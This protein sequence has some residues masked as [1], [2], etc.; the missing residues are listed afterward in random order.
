MDNKSCLTYPPYFMVRLWMALGLAPYFIGKT[1]SLAGLRHSLEKIGFSVE[2]ST[3]IFHYPYPDGL[4]RWLEHSLHKL[5][6]GKLDNAIRQGL[7]LLDKLEGKRTRYLTGRYIAVKAI[8]KG[9][10]EQTS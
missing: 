5:S 7:A 4:I 10:P 6:R 1:L 3:A 9:N 8:K 2:E